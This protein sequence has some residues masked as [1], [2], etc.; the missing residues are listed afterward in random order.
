VQSARPR[1]PGTRPPPLASPSPVHT[2]RLYSPSAALL[3]PFVTLGQISKAVRASNALQSSE[4]LCHFAYFDEN[5]VVEF[6]VLIVVS[7]THRRLALCFCAEDMF[8]NYSRND[9]WKKNNMDIGNLWKWRIKK[10]IR[11]AISPA[12]RRVLVSN[13]VRGSFGTLAV[14]MLLDRYQDYFG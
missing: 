11:I 8:K 3:Q 14:F 10:I 12:P 7:I 4:D 9:T 6:D 1:P 13:R 2:C 5:F